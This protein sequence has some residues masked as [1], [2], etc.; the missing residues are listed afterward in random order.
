VTASYLT[1]KGLYIRHQYI[2]YLHTVEASNLGAIRA[3][4]SVSQTLSANVAAK[5]IR[6]ALER[7][8]GEREGDVP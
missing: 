5:E 6:N 2:F 8:K 3:N 7:L 4:G 1:E